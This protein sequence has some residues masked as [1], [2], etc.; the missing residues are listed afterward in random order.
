MKS[1]RTK[2]VNAAQHLSCQ[3]FA[4]RAQR[5]LVSLRFQFVHIFVI[6]WLYVVIMIAI[7]SDSILKGVLRFLL[8]GALPCGLYFW[9]MVRR[10]AA[11]RNAAIEAESSDASMPEATPGHANQEK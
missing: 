3:M 11:E 4:L 1:K 8:L 5:F 10:R 2:N 7:V 6:G 9:F